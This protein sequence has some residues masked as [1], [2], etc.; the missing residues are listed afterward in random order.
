[1]HP[2]APHYERK[3][4]SGRGKKRP[5][6]SNA[7]S[8]STTLNHP[9]SSH[10]LDDTLDENDDE[11]FYSNSSSSSQTSPHRPMLSL[12]GVKTSHEDT[13]GSGVVLDEEELRQRITTIYLVNLDD[14]DA[15][16]PYAMSDLRLAI[17]L[18]ALRSTHGAVPKTS[19][20]NII[21]CK[22]WT[23]KGTSVLECQ[24]HC[25]MGQNGKLLVLVCFLTDFSIFPLLFTPSPYPSLFSEFYKRNREQKASLGYVFEQHMTEFHEAG[26]LIHEQYGLL[27]DVEELMPAL[28]MKQH[29]DTVLVIAEMVK[30]WTQLLSLRKSQQFQHDPANLAARARERME[31]E[32]AAEAVTQGKWGKESQSFSQ[33]ILGASAGRGLQF[34]SGGTEASS[35]APS[36][37]VTVHDR[38]RD[39]LRAM[40]RILTPRKSKFDSNNEDTAG[41]G[42]TVESARIIPASATTTGILKGAIQLLTT[43]LDKKEN[44]L[45]LKVKLKDA[46]VQKRH[47]LKKKYTSG[48][49]TGCDPCHTRL[50]CGSVP[51][52]LE[53][54][55]DVETGTP[56]K[57][58]ENKKEAN[59]G[60]QCYFIFGSVRRW[61]E[62]M[63]FGWV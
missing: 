12:D 5:R 27:I 18:K 45:K 9:S 7:S 37:K 17:V 43:V 57:K 40:Q 26:R 30:D 20:L 44:K 32:A 19:C 31:F 60:T 55:S 36:H 14:V 29:S 48:P 62:L 50:L 63:A 46:R 39:V 2:L 47:I 13:P 6:K 8:S 23:G 41:N 10:P 24:A 49:K 42:R 11:S 56:R 1:M 38:K 33:Q 54:R 4:R 28:S 51:D 35:S 21:H 61:L 53:S 59:S 34:T 15:L 3:T 58:K 16:F 25:V 22:L 52:E